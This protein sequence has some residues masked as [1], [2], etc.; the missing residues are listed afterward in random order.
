MNLKKV[1]KYSGG[2]T[3]IKPS[4]FKDDR[5]SFTKLFSAT[6]LF[7]NYL[8]RQINL[9]ENLQK[10]TLRGLHYQINGYEES[11]IFVVLNGKI[12]LCAVDVSPERKIHSHCFTLEVINDY[13]MVVIPRG[14]ATGYLTLVD[15]TKLLYYSDND[16]RPQEERGIRWNDPSLKIEW[17]VNDPIVSEKDLKWPNLT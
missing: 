17:D 5:G 10:H 7:E 6:A 16:Y 9:V 11:K 12:K 4:I 15:N 3:T 1:K 13:T 8:P 14:F 2:I